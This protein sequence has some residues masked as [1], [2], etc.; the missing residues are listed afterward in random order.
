M[1]RRRTAASLSALLAL[2]AAAAACATASASAT[3]VAKSPAAQGDRVGVI[4]VPVPPLATIGGVTIDGSAYG[5][6]LTTVP[7]H[8]DEVYGL[9]DRGP[10]VDGPD[11]T[12]IEPIPSFQP[13]IGRFRISGGVAHLVQR[14]GLS[15]PKGQPYNG[16]VNQLASTGETITDLHGKVLTTSRFGY[17]PEGLVALADGTFWV[18]DEYGPFITHFDARGRQI[19]RLSPFAGSLPGELRFR[20]S[21]RGME[22]LTITPD[23]RILVGI[24]Q[25]ALKQPDLTVKN[26]SVPLLRIVTVDLRTRATHEYAYLLDDP[27]DTG[28]AVSEITALSATRF[29]VDERDGNPEP[30]AYKRLFEIDLT[31][32]TDIG[33]VSTVPGTTYAADSGGLL[34]GGTTLEQLVGV[35][36]AQQAATTLEAAGIQPV[37][38]RL[39]LDLGGLV[40]SLD[41]SGGFFGHDKIEGVAVTNGGCTLLVSNDSDFGIDG[42]TGDTPPFTLTPKLLPDGTQDTGEILRVDLP[43]PLS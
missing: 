36:T 23:G 7:G 11:D 3:P 31:G 27:A 26:K 14:I 19:G 15:G 43:S 40:S 13:A 42:V 16:R 20:D 8:P 21:N 4:P 34:V 17:D 30:G 35:V 32:A 38:K 6:A 28:T 29:L 2:T 24:M 22:G 9:T 25:S 5:S 18:S 12:K 39:A 10:N 33:P 37:G 41:P 1:T